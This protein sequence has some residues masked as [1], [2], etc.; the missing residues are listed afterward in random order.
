[1][2]STMTEPKRRR[3]AGG[4]PKS[5]GPLKEMI[6]AFKATPA[7]SQWFLGL[8]DHCRRK[9]G[10]PGISKTDVIIRALK[11]FAKEVDYREEPPEE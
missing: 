10:F 3:G 7:F 8:V 11:A 4:R 2:L 1:M 9:F 5:T 6:A